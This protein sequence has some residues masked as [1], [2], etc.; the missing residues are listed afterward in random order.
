MATRLPLFAL[1]SRLF[2]STAL[3]KAEE[4]EPEEDEVVKLL[5]PS[6]EVDKLGITV[7]AW[8]G[9]GVGSGGQGMTRVDSGHRPH[10]RGQ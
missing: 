9:V 10:V 4:D 2:T 7:G 1:D 5:V 6:D 8:V 3:K